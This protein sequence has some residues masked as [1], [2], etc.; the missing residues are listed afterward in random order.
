MTRIAI[1][2]LAA[3][4][5]LGAGAPPSQTDYGMPEKINERE[6]ERDGRRTVHFSHADPP[7]WD[8]GPDTKHA[9]RVELPT[10]PRKNMPLL[11][12]LHS[13]GGVELGDRQHAYSPYHNLHEWG[14]VLVFNQTRGG[15]AG[16][17]GATQIGKDRDAFATQHAADEK[18]ILSTVH[19][20]AERYGIDRQRIYLSGVSMGGSG[21]LGVGMGRGDVFAAVRAIVPAG[22]DHFD[23]RTRSPHIPD[24]PPL[25][26]LFSQADVWARGHGAHRK[27]IVDR[28]V[29]LF[30]SWGPNGHSYY[31]PLQ[32]EAVIDLPWLSIR[33]DRAYPVF[34]DASTDDRY[35]KTADA[36]YDKLGQTNGYFR[37]KN[38][39]DTP[40][41]FEIELRLVT[42]KQLAPVAAR[43]D[44][45]LASYENHMRE[46]LEKSPQHGPTLHHMRLLE[47]YLELRK[48]RGAPEAPTESTAHVVIRRLQKFKLRDGQAFRWRLV[49]GDK[50]AAEG[51]GRFDADAPLSV[52]R[53]TITD[54]PAPTHRR[55]VTYGAHK[56]A[57][58]RTKLTAVLTFFKGCRKILC[59]LSAQH[60]R[61]P[62]ARTTT[63]SRA[64]T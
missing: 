22:H 60:F 2:A 32:H 54:A 36:D 33:R 23:V 18:R 39:A 35:E 7:A 62:G 1:L 56:C 17:W 28:H 19:Y 47:P 40:D 30:A 38:I 59:A 48:Q 44:R 41:R 10:E 34:T 29:G 37:W 57:R 13:V 3:V 64:Q 43:F 21:V 52:G 58:A 12:I 14:Y 5:S 27:M 63:P 42:T 11:V 15:N 51:D 26:Y 55:A 46:R 8:S 6:T 20:V 49:R 31:D 61:G 53:L 25:V 16:W 45:Q 4:V 50:T 9:F 24:P